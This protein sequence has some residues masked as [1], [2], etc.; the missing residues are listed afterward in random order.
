MLTVFHR[1][2][3]RCVDVDDGGTLDLNEVTLLLN[4]MAMK[5][6]RVDLDPH[7]VRLHAIRRIARLG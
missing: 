3:F 6:L 5:H 2:V 7:E 1:Y 4:Y